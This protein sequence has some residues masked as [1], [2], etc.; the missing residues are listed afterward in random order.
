MPLRRGAVAVAIPR[1]AC[2]R[3]V[4]FNTPVIAASDMP[5]RPL[6]VDVFCGAG[7]FALGVEQ[8]GF[9]VVAAVDYDP[10]HAAAHEYN[11]P[12]TAVV[13]A[14][15]LALTLER[16][17]AAVELGRR[18]HGHRGSW[19]GEV[20]LLFG[21]PPCQGFS[22]IGQRHTDDLR[23]A[24]SFAFARIVREL[25]PRVFVFENVPGMPTVPGPTG[26]PLL[27]QV[28]ARMRRAGY[29]VAAPRVLNAA[30]FGVPQ[31]RRRLIVIGVRS[32]LA[33]QAPACPVPTVEPVPKRPRGQATGM[34]GQAPDLGPCVGDALADLPDLD[35]FAELL[36]RDHVALASATTR[37]SAAA[38]SR[39]A[40][41][42]RDPWRDVDDLSHRRPYDPA[43]LTSSQRTT[44][45][46]GVVARF[47]ATARG[48]I[49][50]VSRFYRLH[51]DGLSVTLRAGTGYDRGSFN[52]PR[53]LHYRWPR[54]VSV[55]E[56]ARLHSMPDWFRLHA[57][58]WHGFRQV[59][60]AV[61]P[62]LARA[63]AGAIR[64]S[65]DLPAV[66][67]TRTVS[68]GSPALLELTMQQAAEHFDVPTTAGPHHGL[69]QRGIRPRRPT[70][71][72]T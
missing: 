47:G 38:A 68:L 61:P 35:G 50:P 65:L 70:L 49:D 33:S 1:R 19:D 63:V 41:S 4:R 45:A 23:N 5:R 48:A 12:D 44:H 29:R 32:D 52:A 30:D 57:T 69:R 13:C 39:Y 14:D 25:R 17:Q 37:R 10:I 21:G 22:V 9:D 60:N 20:D 8:A 34:G 28:V 36:D 43:L 58:K 3:P 7:G 16:L 67:S 64:D 66:R 54:V 59:G 2:V 24:L 72:P 71:T 42:M 55:R 15:V 56:A 40:W 27:S 53:P 6:A 18:R 62:L 51:P 31:D 11:F 46:P 26:R